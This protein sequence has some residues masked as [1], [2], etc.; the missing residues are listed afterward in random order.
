MRTREIPTAQWSDYLDRFSR[1]HGGEPVT[2]EIFGPEIGAHT[3]VRRS[4]LRGV[5]AGSHGQPVIDILVGNEHDGHVDHRVAHPRRVYV[6][7]TEAEMDEIL[8]IEDDDGNTTM[9]RLL[10]PLLLD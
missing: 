1:S 6:G 2:I 10:K 3:E 9:V 8:E 5:T 4:T 7:L